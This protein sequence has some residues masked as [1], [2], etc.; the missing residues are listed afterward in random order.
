[1]PSLDGE[2]LAWVEFAKGKPAT[3]KLVAS[4]H[5]SHIK[6]ALVG[7]VLGVSAGISLAQAGKDPKSALSVDNQMDDVLSGLYDDAVSAG[8]KHGGI[9]MGLGF[10]TLLGLSIAMS[11][12]GKDLSEISTGIGNTSL[13]LATSQITNGVANGSTPDV[14]STAVNN[15]VASPNRLDMIAQTEA[16]RGFNVGLNE[17]F[18]SNGVQQFRWV[19]IEGTSCPECSAMAGVHDIT[20]SVPPLH[21][22]CL[23]TIEPIE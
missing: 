6:S 18:Q 12:I 5:K 23:C 15:A 2:I 8:S 4:K 7:S 11:R 17:S 1:M 13:N 9:L 14:I 22:D 3:V 20:D 21:P 16:N 10:G 19:N